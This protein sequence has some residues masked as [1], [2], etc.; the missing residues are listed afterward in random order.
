MQFP[1]LRDM[2]QNGV[3]FGHQVSRWHPKMRPFIYGVK[4]GIH[5]LDLE[6]T[7]KRLQEAAEFAKKTAF[8]GGTIL[9]VG[10]KRQAQDIIEK[11]AKECKMPYANKRWVGGLLTN[12]PVLLKLIKKYLNLKMR[13]ETGKLAKYTKKEQLEFSREIEKLEDMVGGIASLEKMPDVVFILDLKREKIAYAEALKKKVKVI[14]VCDTNVDPTCVDY[15]IPANDD[16]TKSIELIVK[17]IA[18][19]INEGRGNRVAALSQE[20]QTSTAF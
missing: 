9:F 11:A 12:F 10:T 20:T 1:S 14:A 5:V 16:A 19:A 3:H 13:Q 7:S 17:V 18:Q 8:E 6:K 15:P 2:L 4:N